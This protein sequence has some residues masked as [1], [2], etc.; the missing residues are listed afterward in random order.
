MLLPPCESDGDVSNLDLCTFACPATGGPMAPSS[1]PDGG[2]PVAI[3][4]AAHVV[5]TPGGATARVNTV[6]VLWPQAKQD[7]GHIPLQPTRPAD[8]S[9]PVTERGGRRSAGAPSMPADR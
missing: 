7:H 5:P 1:W 8:A 6:E 4:F 9:G 2:H 3:L